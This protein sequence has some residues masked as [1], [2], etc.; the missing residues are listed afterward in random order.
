MYYILYDE[1][2]DAVGC[3]DDFMSAN[4]FLRGALYYGQTLVYNDDDTVDFVDEDLTVATT[5]TLRLHMPEIEIS[6]FAI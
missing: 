3:F 2:N 5:F 4:K 6:T 1:S